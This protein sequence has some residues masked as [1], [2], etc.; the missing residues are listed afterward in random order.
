M[1][2]GIYRILSAGRTVRSGFVGLCTHM[3]TTCVVDMRMNRIHTHMRTHTNTHVRIYRALMSLLRMAAAVSVIRDAASCAYVLMLR[4]MC[5]T[6]VPTL[7]SP[8]ADGRWKSSVVVGAPP[9]KS[10]SVRASFRLRIDLYKLHRCKKRAHTWNAYYWQSILFETL[11]GLAGS[12]F[13]RD[14]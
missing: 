11:P 2:L 5:D 12:R 1:L 4:Y 9:R 14:Q 8:D 3:H 10:W 13:K 7:L 6:Y